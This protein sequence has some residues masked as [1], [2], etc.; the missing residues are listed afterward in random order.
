MDAVRP[1][2]HGSLQMHEE[3]SKRKGSP[4]GRRSLVHAYFGIA[5]TV[6]DYCPGRGDEAGRVWRTLES[7]TFLKGLIQG[8]E[9]VDMTRLGSLL[10]DLHSL[11]TPPSARSDRAHASRGLVTRRYQ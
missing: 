1:I 8:D 7:L 4:E 6:L 2:F 5:Q 11:S 9:G 3:I 10:S